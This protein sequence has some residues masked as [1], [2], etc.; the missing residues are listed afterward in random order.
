MDII[1]TINRLLSTTSHKSLIGIKFIDSVNE[2]NR[3]VAEV[4]YQGHSGKW[5]VFYEDKKY[6]RDFVYREDALNYLL[7]NII[8]EILEVEIK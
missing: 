5:Y 1:K 8:M 2:N 6:D 7:N 4:V 3:I